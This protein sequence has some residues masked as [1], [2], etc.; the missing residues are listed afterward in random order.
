MRAP[1]CDMLPPAQWGSSASRAPSCRPST[2]AA[3]CG[4][5]LNGER[6]KTAQLLWGGKSATDLSGSFR[7]LW[8]RLVGDSV[9]GGRWR[10]SIP[11][12]M[13]SSRRV[14]VTPR[15]NE[16]IPVPPISA[17][18]H[19]SGSGGHVGFVRQQQAESAR[20]GGNRT[21]NNFGEVPPSDQPEKVRAPSFS[22]Q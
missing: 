4:Q 19:R 1:Q 5:E 14:E 20:A 3:G 21:R 8:G 22:I 7:A 17:P 11:Q 16:G 9:G 12:A 13:D 2:T 15:T 18:I 6:G 10:S